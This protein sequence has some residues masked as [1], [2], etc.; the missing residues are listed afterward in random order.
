MFDVWSEFLS[1][2]THTRNAAMM[3]IGIVGAGIVGRLLAYQ[4][5]KLNFQ[6]TLFDVNGFAAANTSMAAAGLLSVI[7]ELEKSDPIIYAL[8][9]KALQLWP[10]IIQ[11]LDPSIFFQQRGSL[12]I[13]A[14]QDQAELEIF[15]QKIS[16]AISLNL[17]LIN[18]DGII[19]LEPQLSKFQSGYFLSSEGNLDNQTLMKSLE[20]YL[21]NS[22]KFNLQTRLI[23]K[24]KPYTVEVNHKQQK[25]D[26]IFDCRGVNAKDLFSQ[27]RGVRGEV[28]WLHAPQVQISRPIRLLNSRYSLYIA[29]RPNSLYIVGATEIEQEDYS[30]IS[31]RS[32]LELL[33]SCYFVHSGFA[34]A[35]IINTITHCRPVLQNSLPQMLLAPGLI[36]INGLYR[37]GYLI[38]PALIEDVLKYLISGVDAIHFKSLWSI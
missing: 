26:W 27:L 1:D 5:L 8:G 18:Q 30:E 36:A 29:P 20:H 12:A 37:F 2:A 25:F 4:L 7:S 35:R 6:V 11:E 31:V 17:E 24:I 10:A 9:L 33:S 32:A 13:A 19:A 16:R 3:N 22:P 14:K 23:T 38:A 21:L 15:V 34:E 28:L